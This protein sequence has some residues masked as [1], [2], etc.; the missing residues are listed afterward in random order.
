LAI[1]AGVV[2]FGAVLAYGIGKAS[3]GVIAGGCAGLVFVALFARGVRDRLRGGR[4]A[5]MRDGDQL[6]GGELPRPLPF[7]GTTFAI[8]SDRQGSWVIV[9]EA[10]NGERVRLSAGGWA[11][12]GERFVTRKVAERGLE[13]MGLTRRV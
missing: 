1:A 5:L 12:D 3:V 11:F 13:G 2:V 6:V 7:A 10:G 8:E 9:L 4:I